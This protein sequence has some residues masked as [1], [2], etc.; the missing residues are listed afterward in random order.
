MS[1]AAASHL[2]AAI[3][4]LI[5]CVLLLLSGGRRRG[6]LLLLLAS[7]ATALWAALVAAAEHWPALPAAAAQIAELGRT[8]A[9]LALLGGLV[10]P[11]SP[12]L[13]G[14]ARRRVAGAALVAVLLAIALVERLAEAAPELVPFD[15]KFEIG[16]RLL[17][18]VAGLILTENLFRNT[19][20]D[21]VWGVKFLVFAAGCIFV[22]DF[23][24]YSDALLFGHVNA[25]LFDARGGVNAF[26]APLL[27]IA[28][29]RS[30]TWAIELHVSRAAVFHT[31]TVVG[32]GAY[33]VAMAA[34][35]Y[36]LRTIGGEWGVVLQALFL[37]GAILVLLI[38]LFSG[39]ARAQLRYIIS[40]N[41]YSNKYD[42]R[43]EWR[44]LIARMSSPEG[45]LQDRA[46]RA[47]ADI[48]D[49]SAGALWQRSSGDDAYLP[50]AAWNFPDDLP[51]LSADAP[52]VRFL[53][54]QAWIVDLS[55][56]ERRPER[57]EGLA[58]PEWFGGLPQPWL[59]APIAHGQGLEAVLVLSQPRA[60]REL[61][62]EDFEL[63]KIVSRQ[64][65]SYLAEEQAMRRLVDSQQLERFNKRFAFLIHDIKNIASQ[66]SIML[67][68][69]ERHGG[70][71]EFQADAM[72]TVRNAVDKMSKLLGQ[73]RAD[74]AEAAAE[75]RPAA[76]PVAL[77]PLVR[78]TVSPWLGGRPAVAI[79]VDG[80][81]PVALADPE[82][83]EQVVAHLVQNAIEAA[84]PDGHV[85]LRLSADPQYASVEIVDDGPGMDAAFIRNQLFR[86]LA[87]TKKSGSGLGAYQ[88]RELVRAMGGQLEVKSAPGAGATFRV[89]LRRAAGGPAR[90]ERSA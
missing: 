35:G 78:R 19:R 5:L 52:L 87:T 88:A 7:A 68:N 43:H 29:A 37:T 42:Y 22:Y 31:T 54:E 36:W 39:S 1:I 82:A 72:R 66:L 12:Y 55:E 59:V 76:M 16:M 3:A 67:S 61:S 24:L 10:A 32:S 86:P 64:L 56:V 74:R 17:L 44:R 11:A 71:P 79:E 30:R 73:L 20:P 83:V 58:L 40:R 65:A 85:L 14:A 23:F 27:A 90:L 4:F 21:G 13:G 81:G 47:M 84:G 26:A 38:A 75:S 33:L 2:A 57:Y 34:T 48:L 60:R 70:N 41:F 63:L 25:D 28:A 80:D 69:A 46:I 9:W 62:G 49:C 15:A 8:G 51:A 53:A 89:S 18:A 45:Q 50:A 77:E 6:T